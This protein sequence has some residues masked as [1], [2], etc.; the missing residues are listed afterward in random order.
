VTA[1]HRLRLPSSGNWATPGIQCRDAAA[2]APGVVLSPM[3]AANVGYAFPSSGQPRFCSP[4]QPEM[5][6]SRPKIP[7]IPASADVAQLVEHFTRNEVSRVN[8]RSSGSPLL[9]RSRPNAGHF[10]DSEDARERTGRV[11]GGHHHRTCC[12]PSAAP[13]RPAS[14]YGRDVKPDRECPL[15]D[16]GEVWSAPPETAAARSRP[17][18]A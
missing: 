2:R 8:A 1:G 16:K 17:R 14:G 11:T 12:S 18:S 6:R 3:S 5:G 4:A 7:E 9:A 13:C 10:T 15:G